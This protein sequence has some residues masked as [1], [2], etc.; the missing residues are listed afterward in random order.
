[1]RD[2]DHQSIDELRQWVARSR[3]IVAFTGAG[4]STE[5][6]V[7]D[8][9]SP[10]SPWLVNKP[11]PYQAFVASEDVRR[12]AWRRKFVMDDHYRFAQP[13]RG[14]AALA[15]LYA[16]GVLTCIV[17]QNIDDLHQRSGV[18][19][20]AVIELHGNGTYATCLDCGL[21]HELEP[22]RMAFE[23]TGEAP[24]C[25]ACGGPVKSA[26]V[27]F[28][29][30]MPQAAMRRASEAVASC[31]LLLVIGSSLVVQP[32]A[33]FPL[34]AKQAGAL[35]ALLNREPTPLDGEAD[36]ILRGDI[37]DRLSSVVDH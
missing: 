7:P 33:R 12:E 18:P 1:M 17:T 36:L 20:Q 16:R 37:G 25:M 31:D 15:A 9:R 2:D 4:I 11:I 22:I 29:Q 32:A 13:G 6:G 27:S 26:T 28:G 19:A 21:R 24:R 34:M 23:Q 30:T 8:F 35:L 5:C 3:R 14:H 10:G